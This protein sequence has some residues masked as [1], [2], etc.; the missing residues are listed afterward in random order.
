MI[1]KQNTLV[2]FTNKYNTKDNI[3]KNIYWFVGSSHNNSRKL[4]VFK[5]PIV[6]ICHITIY[7]PLYSDVTVPAAVWNGTHRAP[8]SQVIRSKN[9]NVFPLRK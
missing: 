9:K 1:L 2:G 3:F 6:V 8:G 5:W 4:F 7:L